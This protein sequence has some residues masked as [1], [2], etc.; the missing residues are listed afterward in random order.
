MSMR[1]KPWT[2]E[3]YG[4]S[5]ARLVLTKPTFRLF[6]RPE[7]WSFDM[8][9]TMIGTLSCVTAFRDTRTAQDVQVDVAP[10][11]DETPTAASGSQTSQRL[12][13]ESCQHRHPAIRRQLEGSH[14]HA[15][16]RHD[17]LLHLCGV[18]TFCAT[19][20]SSK[21]GHQAA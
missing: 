15:L 16:P 8:A 7:G 2:F 17:D 11:P 21:S 18:H 4:G 9:V 20:E 6:L 3:I 13:H 12:H 1:K 19:K 14:H 10:C 5:S